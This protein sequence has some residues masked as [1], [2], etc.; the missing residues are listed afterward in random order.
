MEL[1]FEDQDIGTLLESDFTKW[2][3]LLSLWL[4]EILIFPTQL[5][6]WWAALPIY[7][8]MPWSGDVT[9]AIRAWGLAMGQMV[10]QKG[11]LNLSFQ[12]SSSNPGAEMYVT[13]DIASYGRQLG[14]ILDVLQPFVLQNKDTL[15]NNVDQK[16]LTDFLD[17]A[18]SI[19]KAVKAM[20]SAKVDVNPI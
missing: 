15:F 19:K 6:K 16:E 20:T 3:K 13:Q 2:D 4:K 11:L 8:K 7:T 9:Q 1:F 10:S 5:W 12:N 17:M 18:D 14:R